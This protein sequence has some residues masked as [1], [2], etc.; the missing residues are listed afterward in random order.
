MNINNFAGMV[1]SY[2]KNAGYSQK[3]LANELGMNSSVLTHKLNGTGRFVLTYPEIR[4]IVKTLAKLEAITYKNQVS[5]LLQATNCPNFSVE[6]WRTAPLNK[7]EEGQ[8]LVIQAP[9]NSKPPGNPSLDAS[10]SPLE[11]SKTN[12]PGQWTS[13]IGREHEIAEVKRLLLVNPLLTLTGS[14][15]IGKTRLA[16]QVG[17][18][19]VN[20][21]KDGVWL[22]ELAP[23]ADPSLVVQ[24]IAT[25]LG[26]SEQPGRSLLT[27]LEYY[28]L[29]RHLLLIL[30]NC[31]HLVE[32]CAPIV[33]T[34]LR[35][36][37]GL[38]VLA[39]SRESLAIS[40]EVNF[41]VPSLSLPDSNTQLEV[42]K[43]LNYEGINLFIERATAANPSFSLTIQN[44][45]A[46]VQVCRHLDGISLAIELAA[47]R[48]KMMPVAQLASRLDDRF[49]VLTNGNRTAL[50][51]QKTLKA[52]VDWSY[53]LLTQAEQILLARLS[54]FVGGWGLKAAEE[55]CSGPGSENVEGLEKF[56][57]MNA[58]SGLLN[59]S[60]VQVEEDD[61]GEARYFFLETIR[62]YGL[63]KLKD[64]GEERAIR[65]RHLAYYATLAEEI[66]LKAESSAQ[67]EVLKEWDR[68]LDNIRVCIDYGLK[69]RQVDTIVNFLFHFYWDI[70]GY[71]SE[72]RHYL[73]QILASPVIRGVSLGRALYSAG[74]FA[75]RQG[76]L[77]KGYAYFEQC[78]EVSKATGDKLLQW[79]S[80]FGL[81]YTHLQIEISYSKH[82]NFDLARYYFD[83]MPAL[84][85]QLGSVYVAWA[86]Q[87]LSQVLIEQGEYAYARQLLNEAEIL[88]RELGTRVQLVFILG[89][90]NM[91]SMTLEDYITARHPLKEIESISNETGFQLGLIHF[92]SGEGIIRAID[93]KFEEARQY[94]DKDLILCL[95]GGLTA[96]SAATLVVVAVLI[97]QVWH[98]RGETGLPEKLACLCGAIHALG[99]PPDA[100]APFLI[101]PLSK[102]YV[103]ISG[104]ARNELG[105]V[106]FDKA[107]DQGRAMSFEETITYA[108]QALN[109]F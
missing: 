100:K 75:W 89:I 14:G 3:I 22:V 87:H 1:K 35:A 80:L 52:L 57:I 7:L 49:Q 24:T 84:A 32:E 47:A 82:G 2:L 23:L 98:N 15:G 96:V 73:E 99:G 64:R 44:A 86:K 68:E 71:Y 109:S 11:S 21:F 95:K 55:V 69:E 42:V 106:D 58:L 9:N 74:F 59:K 38:H 72:G 17:F 6:E 46:V 79:N 61:N 20:N 10:V 93:G 66:I 28:L 101:K 91:L 78:L 108:R 50:P 67:V 19:L 16:L 30:D 5:D 60:L 43:L 39:T 94:M 40:G 27:T 56:E 92:Y 48:V 77:A 51:R 62:Q 53:E 81:A 37:K 88:S 36:S 83:Q 85:E 97:N 70:R 41:R 76:D 8:P 12:L 107:F 54:I 33:D 31:E 104:L 29:P 26:L 18:N 90:Q 4:A 25:T 13:F 65:Q 105:E 34:L 63:E 102:Y 45:E 103:E